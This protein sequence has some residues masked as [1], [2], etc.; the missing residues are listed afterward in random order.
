MKKNVTK[1]ENFNFILEHKSQV[2]AQ[3]T[4]LQLLTVVFNS[5]WTSE[6]PELSIRYP[7][8]TLYLTHG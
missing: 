7:N 4:L 5:S 1:I 8:P 6:P 2:A 3:Y